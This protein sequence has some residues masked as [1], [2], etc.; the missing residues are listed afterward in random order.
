MLPDSKTKEEPSLR[1]RPPRTE[2][3]LRRTTSVEET[4]SEPLMETGR[5]ITTAIIKEN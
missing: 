1:S 4:F 5:V 2:T 3:L